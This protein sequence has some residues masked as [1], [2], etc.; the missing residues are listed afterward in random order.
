MTKHT[1][2]RFFIGSV[3]AI[4]GGLVLT[5][6]AGLLAFANGAL[7]YNGPDVIGVNE[8]AFGWTMITVAAVG[9]L[10]MAGGAIGQF[11]SWIGA[12]LNTA[13][14]EDK[15]WFVVL[16]LLGLF[17]F[18]FIAMLIYVIAGPDGTETVKIRGG[19]PARPAPTA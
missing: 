6:V 18:G 16:L 10:V 5:V 15:T 14:L 2:T 19:I 12:V 3:L 1:V 17:S 7:V 4:A 8:S 11:V 13:R 9:T